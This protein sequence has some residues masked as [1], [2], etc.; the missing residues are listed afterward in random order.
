MIT[1]TG[2]ALLDGKFFDGKFRGMEKTAVTRWKWLLSGLSPAARKRIEPIAKPLEVELAGINHG[3]RNIAK[4]YGYTIEPVNTGEFSTYHKAKIIRHTPY[5]HAIHNRNIGNYRDI[6]DEELP[7]MKAIGLRHEVLEALHNSRLKKKSG[8]YNKYKVVTYPE[9][10][11]LKNTNYI[12]NK[13]DLDIRNMIKD[14]PS[15]DKLIRSYNLDPDKFILVGDHVSPKVLA[16]E[17][18][19]INQSYHAGLGANSIKKLRYNY[20]EARTLLRNAG[21]KNGNLYNRALTN[22]DY[23]NMSGN[24]STME[25]IRDIDRETGD[26]Y[27]TR[28]DFS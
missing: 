15:T 18:R 19:L 4:R 24:R 3:S 25:I 12:P 23:K 2:A 9:R 27:L 20:G 10:T 7:I 1:K 21:F 28:I 8:A 22:H 6:P 14:H 17:T 26:K 16:D 13:D 11:A 5:K